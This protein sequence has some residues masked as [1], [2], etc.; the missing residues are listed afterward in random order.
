MG[1]DPCNNSSQ[2]DGVVIEGL[3]VVVIRGFVELRC[4]HECDH[5][6]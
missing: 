2:Q 6:L 4:R 3:D 5:G 1:E